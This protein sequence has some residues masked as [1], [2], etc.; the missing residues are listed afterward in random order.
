MTESLS[1][2]SAP[3]RQRYRFSSILAY[4]DIIYNGSFPHCISF[5]QT[6]AN[7]MQKEAL[8]I[9]LNVPKIYPFLGHRLLKF[10]VKLPFTHL[11]GLILILLASL[12]LGNTFPEQSW[13]LILCSISW[14]VSKDTFTNPQRWHLG[15]VNELCPTQEAMVAKQYMLFF[16]AFDTVCRHPLSQFSVV[17]FT[18]DLSNGDNVSFVHCKVNFSR[19]SKRSSYSQQKMCAPALR[20][21]PL[22]YDIVSMTPCLILLA[23]VDF[24]PNRYFNQLLMY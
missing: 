19:I 15:V 14:R 2:C 16:K 18:N 24:L 13:W 20:P 22:E 3:F 10:L 12:F 9:S 23:K 21:Q 8:S 7:D 17:N 5:S 4:E 1:P 6:A 11:C